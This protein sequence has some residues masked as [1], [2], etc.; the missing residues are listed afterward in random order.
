MEHSAYFSFFSIQYKLYTE[1][2]S[3][4]VSKDRLKTAVIKGYIKDW[5]YQEITGE[6]YTA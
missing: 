6:P 5:E 1:N 4:G 3:L 2:P